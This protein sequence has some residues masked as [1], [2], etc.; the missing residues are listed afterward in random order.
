MI[1]DHLRLDV[2]RVETEMVS[3][4]DAK[5]HRVEERAG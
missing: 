3:E 2:R 1:A 4:M 5:P